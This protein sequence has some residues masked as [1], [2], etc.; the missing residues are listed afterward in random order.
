MTSI[1]SPSHA[2]IL[3][4]YGSF[5]CSALAACS[6]CVF[7]NPME[8]VKTRLQLDGERA[9]SA[10]LSSSSSL[11]SSTRM[12]RGVGH[13]LS[14]IWRAE[15][16]QGIQAGL[17]PALFYQVT[18]NGSR[19]GLY[20]PAQRFLKTNFGID[21][22]LPWAKGLSGAMSGAVG[23]TLGSPFFLVKSRLQAQ[24]NS[25]KAA[26]SHRYSGMMDGLSQIIKADGFRGL[27]R[28]VDGALPR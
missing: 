27:M 4:V 8:V 1:S 24:S 23:A 7:T 12:Y 28:G 3:S 17:Q 16:L 18:M 21:T 5:V 15:G 25:F 19:L 13:A 6:A 22:N 26:E 20:E 14:S 9:T 2:P 11:S 10:A